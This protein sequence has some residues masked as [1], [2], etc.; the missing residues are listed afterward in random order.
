[1]NQYGEQ[2]FGKAWSKELALVAK[3]GWML[4]GM[5]PCGVAAFSA[6]ADSLVGSRKELGGHDLLHLYIVAFL[7]LP[8]AVEAWRPWM[9]EPGTPVVTEGG[10]APKSAADFAW[11]SCKLAEALDGVKAVWE[12]EQLQ[13]GQLGPHAFFKRM[14]MLESSDKAV[15]VDVRLGKKGSLVNVFRNVDKW[16]VLV[17]LVDEFNG[18]RLRGLALPKD[19]E[20]THEFVKVVAKFLEGFPKSFGHGEGDKG[21]NTIRYIFKHIMR[22]IIRWVQS[23]TPCDIWKSWTIQEINAFTPDKHGLLSA[24]PPEMCAEEAQ[25]MFGVDAF[26]LSCWAC[27]F[28][29]VQ[30]CNLRAFK[31][32]TTKMQQLVRELHKQHGQEPNLDTLG[33]EYLKIH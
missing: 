2:Q 22:K 14:G 11:C 20:G 31:Q 32:P 5:C 7:K 4:S 17:A 33:S 8:H 9:R 23:R 1:M 30:E 10:R 15:K 6:S 29:G 21:S 13:T 12:Y 19:I 24:L 26:M 16:E 27:L 25:H 28:H 3:H 18:H